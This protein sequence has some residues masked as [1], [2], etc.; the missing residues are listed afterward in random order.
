M[1]RDEKLKSQQM[2][3]QP[4]FFLS[5]INYSSHGWLDFDPF[6]SNKEFESL[7]NMSLKKTKPSMHETKPSMYEDNSQ[8]RMNAGALTIHSPT[9]SDDM[10]KS[11]TGAETKQVAE[12]GVA[13]QGS[14]EPPRGDE[15]RNVEPKGDGQIHEAYVDTDREIFCNSPI[16]NKNGRRG[17][18]PNIGNFNFKIMT[19]SNTDPYIDIENENLQTYRG[20][21]YHFDRF[22]DQRTKQSTIDSI[23]TKMLPNSIVYQSYDARR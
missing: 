18:Q 21:D 5:K 7:K 6:T 12:R 1:K 9:N 22:G 11:G 13:R 19:E 8:P 16:L 14:E 15:P 10:D 2:S 17:D 20:A 4:I 3:E 23:I